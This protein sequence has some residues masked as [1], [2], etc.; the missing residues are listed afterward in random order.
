MEV[1]HQKS[2]NSIKSKQS[3]V[4]KISHIKEPFVIYYGLILQMMERLALDHHHEVQVFVG[5][6]ILVVNLIIV[7]I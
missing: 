4:Y 3:T 1:S 6:K 2:N 7:I 5:V